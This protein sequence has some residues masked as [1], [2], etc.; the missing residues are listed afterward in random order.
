M[1]KSILQKLM[2]ELNYHFQLYR[3]LNLRLY[4][5]KLKIH[6]KVKMIHMV[7]CVYYFKYSTFIFLN[8]YLIGNSIS[9]LYKSYLLNF[10][11]ISL[12]S[13]YLWSGLSNVIIVL[14][15]KD[16]IYEFD[17]TAKY[18]LQI[19]ILHI[20]QSV[21]FYIKLLLKLNTSYFPYNF[22]GLIIK[23]SIS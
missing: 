19:S 5:L 3:F 2:N 14:D 12:S 16:I 21:I 6:C 20:E 7:Y 18:F 13:K 1:T 17:P 11:L 23:L 15:H 9:F 22:N 10:N 4:Y 8:T